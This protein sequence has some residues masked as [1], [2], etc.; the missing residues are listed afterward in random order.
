MEEL[1]SPISRSSSKWSIGTVSM[2]LL[3]EQAFKA[4][5][6]RSNGYP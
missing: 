1:K 2:A 3:G 5:S 6:I 4:R